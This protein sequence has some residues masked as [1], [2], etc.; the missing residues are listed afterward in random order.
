MKR[1]LE[2]ADDTPNNVDMVSILQPPQVVEMQDNLEEPEGE[3]GNIVFEA[4]M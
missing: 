1:K 4:T 2:E 3:G